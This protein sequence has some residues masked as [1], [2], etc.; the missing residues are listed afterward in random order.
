MS[1]NSSII[2]S[3]LSRF[4][5]YIMSRCW[6]RFGFQWLFWNH[7]QAITRLDHTAITK[8]MLLFLVFFL[9]ARMY[10]G[11]GLKN[12]FVVVVVVGVADELLSCF[13]RIW[14]FRK[15]FRNLSK[16]EICCGRWLKIFYEKVNIFSKYTKYL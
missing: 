10:C 3:L 8:E 11:S 4:I 12:D 2:F 13:Q 15:S 14:L 9:T 5:S 1:S 7:F 16:T 6:D